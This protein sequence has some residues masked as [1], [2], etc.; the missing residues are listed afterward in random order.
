M[1]VKELKEILS[2]IPDHLE[3]ALAEAESLRYLGLR[4][5]R[6]EDHTEFGVVETGTVKHP[7]VRRRIN[8]RVI[9][10]P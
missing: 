7:E 2:E 8:K 6:I 9:L 1:T 3:V 5:V 4:T 10:S